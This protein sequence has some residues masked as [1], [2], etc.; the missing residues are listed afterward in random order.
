MKK[1]KIVNL[2]F[3]YKND[4]IFNNLNLEI[5]SKSLNSLIGPNCSGKTTLAKIICGK[6]KTNNV[7]FDDKVVD[8]GTLKQQVIYIDKLTR[9]S[10]SELTIP[11]VKELAKSIVPKKCRTIKEQ[12]IL[13]ILIAINLKPE[14]L[15]LDDVF[16]VI[17]SNIKK[18]IIELIKKKK[19]TLIDITNNIEDS[20]YMDN[21]IILNEGKIITNSKTMSVLKKEKLLKQNKIDLPFMIDL[22][23]KLKFYDLIDEQIIDMDKMVDTIWK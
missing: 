5:K 11:K 6:I 16:S 13:N 4:M 10:I 23:N 21:I 8:R 12:N 22:S 17:D 14:I 1:L 9:L 15:I 20:I 18:E 19:I 3:S 2:D 7:Y